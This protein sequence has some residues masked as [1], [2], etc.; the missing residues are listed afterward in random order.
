M[1]LWAKSQGKKAL[2]AE[3][4]MHSEHTKDVIAEALGNKH[5]RKQGSHTSFTS[6]A[7][8]SFERKP[9]LDRDTFIREH[10]EAFIW[11]KLQNKENPRTDELAQS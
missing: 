11:G 6:A 1:P 7:P 5:E 2:F 4:E 10:Q 9:S 3:H 8:S